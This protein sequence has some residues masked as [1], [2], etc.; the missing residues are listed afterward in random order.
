MD[1]SKPEYVYD[2][3]GT[4]W[5]IYKMRYVGNS[6]Y[7]EKISEPLTHCEAKKKTYRLNGWELK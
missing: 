6:S 2:R 4:W 5:Y 1:K 7:G 3:N